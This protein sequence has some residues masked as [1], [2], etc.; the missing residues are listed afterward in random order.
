MPHFHLLN[1]LFSNP[2]IIHPSLTASPTRNHQ[3][4]QSPRRLPSLLSGKCRIALP[5]TRPLSVSGP[6][7]AAGTIGIACTSS[8]AVSPRLGPRARRHN[9][10]R[11][12]PTLGQ[13][14]GR[15]Q[16]RRGGKRSGAFFR[17]SAFPAGCVAAAGRYTVTRSP[18]RCER[19]R[20]AP[21]AA[22]CPGPDRT[23]NPP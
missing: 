5:P 20:S 16:E 7:T 4:P 23:G 2:Y 9:A 21:A 22:Q 14:A 15:A 12:F 11:S 6:N 8:R 10:A 13:P 19:D 18:T 1:A 3:S 17:V